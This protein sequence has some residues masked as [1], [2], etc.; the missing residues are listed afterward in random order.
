MDP[1]LQER[2]RSYAT[3]GRGCFGFEEL[4]K[5]PLYRRGEE[6]Q[7]GDVMMV[8]EKGAPNPIR[9]LAANGVPIGTGCIVLKRAEANAG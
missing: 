5:A 6:T 8:S 3:H 4:K 1:I 2:L 7:S 9:C